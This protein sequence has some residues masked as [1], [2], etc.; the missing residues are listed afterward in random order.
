VFRNLSQKKNICLPSCKFNYSKQDNFETD[1]NTS[2]RSGCVWFIYSMFHKV[3]TKI[4]NVFSGGFCDLNGQKY[5]ICMYVSA[6]IK[7][8]RQC[9]RRVGSVSTSWATISFLR[10][11]FF[12]LWGRV[13]L[14][15]D[16]DVSEKLISSIFNAGLTSYL[17]KQTENI[18]Q[19]LGTCLPK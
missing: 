8:R 11:R 14:Q 15:G 18:L 19:T 9:M 7:I 16:G 12:W 13:I 10:L 5:T 3:I 4:L 2:K 17:M 6:R 1:I